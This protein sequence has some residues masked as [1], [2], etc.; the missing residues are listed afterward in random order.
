VFHS[1]AVQLRAAVLLNAAL[2]STQPFRRLKATEL[3]PMR[4]RELLDGATNA[5]QQLELKAG[6]QVRA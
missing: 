2:L 3:G 1:W 5:R 6:T 4:V